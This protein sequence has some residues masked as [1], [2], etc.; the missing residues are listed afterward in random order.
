MRA[1]P[2]PRPRRRSAGST[3][4]SPGLARSAWEHLEDEALLDLRL[5]DLRLTIEGTWLQSC[6]ERL[7]SELE[8]KGTPFRPH[9]W[10]STEWFS[11]DDAP[12]VAIPFYLAHRRLM[13]LERRQMGTV[14]G[15]T[16]RSCMRILRHEAGLA[17]DTA[18]R[19]RRRRSWREHFGPAGTPYPQYYRPRPR[20]RRFVQHLEWWYAQSHPAE[21][22]AETFAVWLTPSARWREAY[23]GWPALKKLLYL[24]QLV[25]ELD[26]RPPAVRSRERIESL[27][28]LRSTLREHYRHRRD[29]YGTDLP[30]PFDGELRRIFGNPGASRAI[31][32]PELAGAFLRRHAAA[33]RAGTARVTGVLPYAI[34]Q[35]LREITLRA[36]RLRLRRRCSERLAQDR[37]RGFLTVRVMA[38]MNGG[39][40]DV[41][42]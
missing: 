29:H 22:F 21:D 38:Y 23:A 14:E 5:C 28:T 15:G 9:V 1:A 40:D 31:R 33:L 25:A 10:L 3:T 2:A 36:D 26:G 13:Q 12:G 19:L 4:P 39:V 34:D 7:Y 35:F 41:A 6:V 17:F 30:E 16:V 24:D 18:Y 27:P 37:V 42:L 32:R 20:S 8:R 11:P